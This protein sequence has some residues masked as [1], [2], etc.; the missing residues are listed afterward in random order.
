[1]NSINS[2]MPGKMQDQSGFTIIELMIVVGIAAILSIIAMPYMNDVISNQRL[3][4]A[5]TEM[6]LSLLLARSEAIKRND[7]VSIVKTGANWTDGWTVQA[8]DPITTNPITLQTTDP[9]SD[10]IT[11]ACNTN[12]NPT[13]DTCPTSVTFT[14][15]GRPDLTSPV[16][17]IE[18]RLYESGN[19]RVWMRC[20]SVSLSGRPEIKVDNDSNPANGCE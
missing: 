5:V 1:M 15:T 9:L 8:T 18:Y 6:H 2:N 12:S 19:P 20:V 17:L 13:A 11:L 4:A 10:K 7:D 16:T 14:R 3:R